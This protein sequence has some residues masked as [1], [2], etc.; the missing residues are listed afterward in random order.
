MLVSQ[1]ETRRVPA[2]L[3]SLGQFDS[4]GLGLVNLLNTPAF[5]GPAT[6][7]TVTPAPLPADRR[8]EI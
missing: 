8:N 2:K 5:P 7:Q 1:N 3:I 4:P 6:T